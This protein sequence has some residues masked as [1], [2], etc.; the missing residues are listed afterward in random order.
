MSPDMFREQL[1]MPGKKQVLQL[2]LDRA[3]E[4]TIAAH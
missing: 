1:L 2:S 4:E 3:G